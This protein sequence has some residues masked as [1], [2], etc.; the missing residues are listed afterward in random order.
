VAFT[1]FRSIIDASFT[2]SNDRM[3]DETTSLL[4]IIDFVE[5]EPEEPKS[6]E[7]SEPEEP[8]SP[9][10]G[11]DEIVE[12]LE[13]EDEEGVA[14]SDSGTAAGSDAEDEE[15]EDG[16]KKKVKKKG[17]PLDYANAKVLESRIHMDMTKHVLAFEYFEYTAFWH[18]SLPQA[19]LT[20]LSSVLAFSGSA[21]MLK[22]YAEYI[23][24]IVGCLS[25]TVVLIQTVGGV[26]TYDLRADRH[27]TAAVL[28]RDLNDE[29]TLIKMKLKQI[30]K[31]KLEHHED[32]HSHFDDPDLTFEMVQ[33]RYAQCL[34]SCSSNAPLRI[35]EAFRGLETN[36]ELQESTEN[37]ALIDGVYG[38]MDHKTMFRNKAYDI[39]AGEIINSGIF[40]HKLPNSKDMIQKTMHK[41]KIR[42]KE[43]K[44][45][46]HDLE[47]VVVPPYQE[48]RRKR[49]F[50]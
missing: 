36:I 33:K 27:K 24:L 14:G 50:C 4:D 30:A 48:P 16:P 46:Y 26:K 12:E 21:E 38:D 44:S 42:L 47:S 5:P 34:S 25:A 15:G 29:M 11:E 43:N 41:L 7:E 32:D 1:F 28:L 37:L 13:G 22:P 49:L 19:F 20:A 31:L 23:S 8:K 10:E 9:E 39:L 6:P 45:F 35:V 2:R 3:A 17:V 18:F 40:P